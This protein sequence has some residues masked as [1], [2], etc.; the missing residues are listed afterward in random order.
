MRAGA[1]GGGGRRGD[2]GFAELRSLL[3]LR[4]ALTQ[5]E[6]AV[7]VRRRR[8]RPGRPASP[9]RSP[10]SGGPRTCSA[11]M[12]L[13]GVDQVLKGFPSPGGFPLAELLRARA[14]FLRLE[15]VPTAIGFQRAAAS[16]RGP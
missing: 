1:G 12:D 11:G 4:R 5:A 2:P 6:G 15:E 10:G 7:P 9:A 3:P 13:R 14:A 16:R 8:R